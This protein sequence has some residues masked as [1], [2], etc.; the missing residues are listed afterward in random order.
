MD[1]PHSHEDPAVALTCSLLRGDP[2]AQDSLIDRPLGGGPPPDDQG[3][4]IQ[5]VPV[6]RS[7][8]QFA[9]SDAGDHAYRPSC[10]RSHK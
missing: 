3:D 6:D 5:D 7:H 1:R 8:G 2:V 4:H 10:N 9:L